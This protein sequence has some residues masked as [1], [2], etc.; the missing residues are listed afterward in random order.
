M[1]N[2]RGFSWHTRFSEIEIIDNSISYILEIGYLDVWFND[3]YELYFRL[4]K[5]NDELIIGTYVKNIFSSSLYI[6][7]SIDICN[8]IIDAAK[9]IEKLKA[10]I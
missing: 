7:I 10:F 3:E 4:F 1:T 6:I 8:K 2:S 9:R 5:E